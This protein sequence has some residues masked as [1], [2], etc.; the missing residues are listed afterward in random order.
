MPNEKL[1]D[2]EEEGEIEVNTI[3]NDMKPM[4]MSET[5]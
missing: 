3:S 5:A 1:L 4:N 2:S